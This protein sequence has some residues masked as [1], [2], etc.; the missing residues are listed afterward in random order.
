MG[1]P[2][3]LLHSAA[4]GGDACGIYCMRTI[5]AMTFYWAA[6]HA[7]TVR[8]HSTSCTGLGLFGRCF[9]L[10]G[11]C[12]THMCRGLLIGPIQEVF[13]CAI[14]PAVSGAMNVRFKDTPSI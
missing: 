12:Y 13:D 2:L 14:S 7:Y 3:E 10:Q 11:P 5:T 1:G 8:F 6:C 4:P 9:V